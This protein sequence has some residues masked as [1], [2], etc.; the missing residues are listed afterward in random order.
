MSH[1]GYGISEVELAEAGDTTL[2][3]FGTDATSTSV[4]GFGVLNILQVDGVGITPIVVPF[5]MAFS[6][7][8]GTYGLATDGGGGPVFNTQWSGF[9][10][11]DI[12][13]VLANN[14]IFPAVGATKISIN[15]DNTLT[16]TSEFGTFSLIAKKDFGGLSVTVF[17]IPEPAACLL[18]GL[19]VIGLG[20]IRRR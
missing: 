20:F 15:L 9:F 13:L 2:A 12:E 1:A 8:G 4:T 6:P 10:S 7:S 5:V 19:A 11:E 14:G 3:G 18:V 16:A 17:T